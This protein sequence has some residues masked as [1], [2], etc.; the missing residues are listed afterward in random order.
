VDLPLSRW[1]GLATP[2]LLAGAL[3]YQLG[4]GLASIAP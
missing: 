4:H 1:L 3:L 2:L